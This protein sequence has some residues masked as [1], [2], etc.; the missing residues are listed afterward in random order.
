M[1]LL[2]IYSGAQRDQHNSII[3]VSYI[4]NFILRN[5]YFIKSKDTKLGSIRECIRNSRNL[6]PICQAHKYNKILHGDEKQ[7]PF[8]LSSDTCSSPQLSGRDLA[9]C[10]HEA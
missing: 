4:E 1:I 9:T 2:K 6:V 8:K 10:R 3:K 5:G 7:D